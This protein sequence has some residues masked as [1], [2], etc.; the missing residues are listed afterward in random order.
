[1][2]RV[3]YLPS[4]D[5]PADVMTKAL[6]KQAMVRARELVVG[7]S[8]QCWNM[9][10]LACMF[11]QLGVYYF[12][13][14]ILLGTMVS[15]LGVG[16]CIIGVHVFTTGSYFFFHQAKLLKRKRVS[17]YVNLRINVSMSGMFSQT[18][19]FNQNLS[20]WDVGS[21]TSASTISSN[22]LV[23]RP[24]VDSS[25]CQNEKRTINSIG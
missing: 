4:A 1:M 21:V 5:M 7:L 11:L 25:H 14:A 15:K 9:H 22:S 10:K 12:Y 16:T 23:R 6:P 18:S 17:K 24:D 13:E 2:L 20:S 8:T 19:S 3:R